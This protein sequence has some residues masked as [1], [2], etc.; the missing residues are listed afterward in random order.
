M[1][2][3]VVIDIAYFADTPEMRDELLLSSKV[4]TMTLDRCYA[5]QGYETMPRDEK[6][7][8]Y[9]RVQSEVKRELGIKGS[10][11]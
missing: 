8:I 7:K 2:E 4:R 5:I 11:T 10:E 1:D 6:L 9:D 3:P